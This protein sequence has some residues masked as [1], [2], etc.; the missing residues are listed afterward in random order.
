MAVFIAMMP[1]GPSKC[2]KLIKYRSKIIGLRIPTGRRQTSWLQFTSRA[3]DLNSGQP[4]TNPKVIVIS[5]GREEDLLLRP[6][7][8]FVNGDLLFVHV[9]SS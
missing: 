8:A 3:E 9:G 6:K 4:R 7:R 2:L 5:Y 1:E